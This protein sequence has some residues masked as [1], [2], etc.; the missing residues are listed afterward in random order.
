MSRSQTSAA[1]CTCGAYQRGAQHDMACRVFYSEEI[2]A[3]KGLT[4][5]E[6]LQH[7]RNLAHELYGALDNALVSL[8]SDGPNSAA[9]S[10]NSHGRAA[11]A[12]AEGR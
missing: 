12:K 7:W 11:H 10:L 5:A 8:D 3:P 4:P 2:S 9:A 6:Q 1:T